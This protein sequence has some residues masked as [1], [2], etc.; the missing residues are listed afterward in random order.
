MNSIQPVDDLQTIRSIM[1]RSSKFLSLSGLSGVLAGIFALA[2]VAVAWFFILDL[3]SYGEFLAGNLPERTGLLMLLD[4]AV[5]L[6]LAFSGATL[7]SYRKSQKAGISFWSLTTKRVLFHLLIPLATGG[8]VVVLLL[9]RQQYDL[10][11]PAMLI[12][13]GLALVNAGK[14]TFGEIHYLGLSDIALG[15]LAAWFT[16][17]GLLFWAIGF[18]VMHIVYGT[19]MYLRHERYR[20][21]S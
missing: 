18:G 3:R 5:V 2:G 11:I 19:L 6:V 15:L 8:L 13:Y 20:T 16:G 21:N 9:I 10:V 7:F 1:E 17:W 12:F 4:A 14:F